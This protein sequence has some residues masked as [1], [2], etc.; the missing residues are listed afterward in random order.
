MVQVESK[1]TALKGGLDIVTGGTDTHL[2]LHEARFAL[3]LMRNGLQA[4]LLL[5]NVQEPASFYEMVTADT[6]DG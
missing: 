6:P 4:S 3:Q 1:L 2:S 5:V